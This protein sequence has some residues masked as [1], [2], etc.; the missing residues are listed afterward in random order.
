MYIFNMYMYSICM[1]L[2]LS[3][4]LCRY[5]LQ[6]RRPRGSPHAAFGWRFRERRSGAQ[7]SWELG[8]R[9]IWVKGLGRLGLLVFR[10]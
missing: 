8:S 4:S 6:E 2:S 5:F 9:Q 10:V 1:Y 3:L 7:R